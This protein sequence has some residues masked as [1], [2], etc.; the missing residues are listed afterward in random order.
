MPAT[1]WKA[2]LGPGPV[3]N[4]AQIDSGLAKRD[5]NPPLYFFA[6]H[7]WILI[8]GM[9][10]WSGPSLNLLI[11]LLTG[12][13][14]FGLARRLLHDGVAAAMVTL[15]WAV[16]PAV[17]MTSSMARMYTLEA[18]FC[19]LLIW[20][21]VSFAD[22]KRAPT[23]PLL[24]AA[25]LALATAGGLLSQ[26]QFVLIVVGGVAYILVRLLRVDRRRCALGL[27]AVAVGMLLVPLVQPGVLTQLRRQ[28]A[29]PSPV[30][31]STAVLRSKINRTTQTLYSFIDADAHR[32]DS[33]PRGPLRLWGLLPGQHLTNLSLLSF[34]ACVALGVALAL[35]RSR[36][37]I[38][39][40][41]WHGG[42]ALVLLIWVGGTI[43]AQ[44]LAF[45]SEPELLSARYLAVVWPLLAFLPVLLS[46]ALLP[47]WPYLLVAILCL[48]FTVPFSRAPQNY[49]ASSGPVAS[50]RGAQR[51]VM[52]C[53]NQG[54]VGL[55]S[56]WLP[57]GAQIYAGGPQTLESG[58]SAWLDHLHSGDLFVHGSDASPGALRELQAR[59]VVRRVPSRL[60]L[61]DEETLYVYRVMSGPQGG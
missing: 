11:D 5:V 31:F 61:D 20:L 15:V 46:R 54:S 33:L 16:A 29:S 59:Y 23:R 6:L 24:S 21:V 36:R 25:L 57:K 35:P 27:L 53:P 55:A 17:R 30:P 18:L 42:M 43:I 50:L 19:V 44:N 37:W 7:V 13:A 56:L 34:W 8:V 1:Q 60:R 32:F 10:F 45:L 14:L 22:P 41:D 51:V 49:A 47:R 3:F 58:S 40:R 26:Y 38:M 28:S 4:F 39:R 9:R 52:D 12:A 2:R 48:G